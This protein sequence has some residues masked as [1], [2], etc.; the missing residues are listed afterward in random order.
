MDVRKAYNFDNLNESMEKPKK[1]IYSGQTKILDKISRW[2]IDDLPKGSEA[3]IFGSLANGKFGKYSEC[4][5]GHLGSDIDV[6]VF[7]NGANKPSTWKSLDVSKT[8]WDLY[9]GI[10]IKINNNLHKTD[11]IIIKE[12][13]EEFARKRVK[14]LGWKLIKLNPM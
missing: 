8:W 6:M 14:D 10:E 12:G 1:F 4:Y 13:M 2:I 3:Y 7:L 5:N 9:S 11:I